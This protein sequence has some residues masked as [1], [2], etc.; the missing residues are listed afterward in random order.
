MAINRKVVTI[1]VDIHD[2]DVDYATALKLAWDSAAGAGNY[3]V[4]HM[5]KKAS[6]SSKE[7]YVVWLEEEV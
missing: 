5:E 3:K 4:A 7:T 6:A 1:S 2:E